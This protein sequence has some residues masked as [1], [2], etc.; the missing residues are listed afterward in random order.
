MAAPPGLTPGHPLTSDLTSWTAGARERVA[1]WLADGSDEETE[2]RVGGYRLVLWDVDH[3]LIVSRGIGGEICRAAFLEVTG[4]QEVRGPDVSGRP[5]RAIFADACRLQGLDPDDYAF[6]DYAAALAEGYRRRAADLR[7]RGHALPGAARA[8]DAVAKLD[9]VRQ[10]V[11]TGNVRRVAEMKLAAFG[12]DQ[13]FDFDLGGYAE[14]SEVRADL[15][16]AAYGRVTGRDGL[17]YGIDEVLVI[18]DTPADVEAARGAG[19]AVLGVATGRSSTDV[20]AAAGADH[21]VADLADTAA[22][23]ALIRGGSLP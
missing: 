16:R 21:V 6:S 23:V 18:G 20:L 15:V 1:G 11:V 2:E 10:T 9:G 17:G 13:H 8:L 19:A 3:T 7:E 5:E 12:L 22:L 14:D 4:E